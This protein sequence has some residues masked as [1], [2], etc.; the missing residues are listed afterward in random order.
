MTV[1][2]SPREGKVMQG[3]WLFPGAERGG[4]MQQV[5]WGAHLHGLSSP[6]GRGKQPQKCQ[7]GTANGTALYPYNGRRCCLDKKAT[8]SMKIYFPIDLSKT[9]HS[10]VATVCTGKILETNT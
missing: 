5:C 4:F 3:A 10:G 9:A 6:G 2:P 1:G 8:V 7:L